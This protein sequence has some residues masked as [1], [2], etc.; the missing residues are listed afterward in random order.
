MKAYEKRCEV[1]DFNA[2]LNYASVLRELTYQMGKRLSDE[3]VAEAFSRTAKRL[4]LSVDSV[5]RAYYN[6]DD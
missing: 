3:K 6:T 4:D 2:V 5:H 1:F